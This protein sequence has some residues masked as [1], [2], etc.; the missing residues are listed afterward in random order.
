M[1]FIVFVLL[2]HFT[3]QIWSQAPE[4]EWEKC[5]GGSSTEYPYTIKTTSDNGYI[6]A[7]WTFSN[8]GDITEN[9]GG[10]DYWIVKTDQNGNILWQ[11]TIGGSRW[12]SAFSA[13]ET[14]DYGYIIIGNSQSDDGDVTQHH[15]STTYDDIWVVKLNSQGDILWEKSLGGSLNDYSHSIQQ[16]F[17]G[18]YILVGVSFS[19]D[20][21]VMY[22]GEAGHPNYWV[23]K[24][25]ESGN[26]VWQKIIEEECGLDPT[27]KQTTDTGFII[28]ANT[29]LEGR[30]LIKLA[31]SGEIQ[32]VKFLDYGSSI[33]NYPY[34]DSIQQTTDGGYV[35]IAI[36]A[37]P[38]TSD[39]F[40][41]TKLDT[42]G[43]IIWQ[44][45]FGGS[46]ED[47]PYSIQQ[48]NDNGYIL[49]GRSNSEDGDLTENYGLDDYWIVKLNSLGNLV[50]QKSL[51]GS[52][53]DYGYSIQQTADGGYIIAGRSDSNDG[54]VTGHHGNTDFWVVKLSPDQMAVQETNFLEISIY[55]N[56]VKET[57]NFTEELFDIKIYNSEGK[58]ILYSEKTLQLNVN[59]I[60]PGTYFL[61]AK[62]SNGKNI[63][64]RII[65]N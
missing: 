12:D 13:Q 53:L 4:I 22:E 43:N 34:T 7:G 54:N 33:A 27:I 29:C 39:D 63:Q 60:P 38:S 46:G 45:S 41:V 20:G 1:K 6:I 10:R 19:N 28:Y 44:K 50:W 48:T 47:S 32:W 42:M 21:D 65:K 18:G 23:V 59:A 14:S 25:D 9:K 16:T 51:G 40:L 58:K 3:T 26:I 61:K 8:D 57:L 15:G 31:D 36:G 35:V 11:K 56:P 64:S 55:P 2:L 49:V 52:N 37:T 17:D 5:F 30:N 62:D 24:L